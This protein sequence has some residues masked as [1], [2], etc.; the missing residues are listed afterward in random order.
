MIPDLSAEIDAWDGRD[1]HSIAAVY[2]RHSATNGFLDALFD[3]AGDPDRQVAATWLIKRAVDEGAT[4]DTDR[5]ARLIDL[6]PILR[7]WEATLHLLQCLPSVAV[8]SARAAALKSALEEAVR[9]DRPFVRAWAY[10]GALVLARHHPAYRDWAEPLCAAAM[11]DEAP[12]VKA[13][14]RRINER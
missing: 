9:S 8:P 7:H 3:L 5:A 1:A 14:L 11:E 2:D 4:L 6:L 13:R 10:G 12:S